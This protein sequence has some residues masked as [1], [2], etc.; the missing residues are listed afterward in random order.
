MVCAP[1]SASD[2]QDTEF[3]S[4]NKRRSKP[5][6]YFLTVSSSEPYQTVLGTRFSEIGAGVGVGANAIQALG[7][8]GLGEMFDRISDFSQCG[9]VW[10]KAWRHD[11][12]EHIG[13]VQQTH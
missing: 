9:D 8:L 4:S 2:A 6:V 11:S 12:N 10:M 13:E 3:T 5:I 7:L 1:R